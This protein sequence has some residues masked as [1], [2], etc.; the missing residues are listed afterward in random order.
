[1]GNSFITNWQAGNEASWWQEKWLG[2]RAGG[3]PSREVVCQGRR[4]GEAR[5]SVGSVETGGDSRAR[6]QVEAQVIRLE[7][8]EGRGRN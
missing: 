1:M 3:A 6:I 5:G 8:E 7:D 4:A 2:N